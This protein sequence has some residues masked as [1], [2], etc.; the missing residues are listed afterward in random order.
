MMVSLDMTAPV[1]DD[2]ELWASIKYSSSWITSYDIH[3]IPIIYGFTMKI[4][5]I[6]D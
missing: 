6:Q 3:P 5:T 2:V 4:Q 1:P